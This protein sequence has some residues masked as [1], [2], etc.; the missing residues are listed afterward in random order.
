MTKPVGTAAAGGA[1]ARLLQRKCGCDASAEPNG[2]CTD[3][4]QKRLQRSAR[5]DG[6][7]WPRD[8]ADVPGVVHDVLRSPGRPLDAATRA[9]FEPRFGQEPAL[10][11]TA[12][13][14]A[15]SSSGGL[16]ISEP[17]D[18]GERE[19][20]RVAERVTRR[21]DGPPRPGGPGFDFSR[22]RVHADAQAAE[23]A[24]AVAARAYTVGHDIVFAAGQFAPTTSAGRGLLAHELAHV[25]QHS[26][27]LSRQP[28]PPPPRQLPPHVA[29]APSLRSAAAGGSTVPCA[30]TGCP[31]KI[32]G[33]AQ[34][35]VPGGASGE[36]FNA[37]DAKPSV[38]M[39]KFMTAEAPALLQGV[40][41]VLVSALS[42]LADRQITWSDCPNPP[43]D[44]PSAGCIWVSQEKEKEA[45]VF[46][47]GT[48]ATIGKQ[49]RE[50]WSIGTRKQL[51]WSA[52][53]IRF[54]RSPPPGLPAA[55][56]GAMWE[57][58]AL[59]G[60]LAAF[61]VSY[62]RAM[63]RPTPAEQQA[64]VTNAIDFL[65][66]NTKTLGVRGILTRLRC[67]LPCAE[68]DESIT[69]VFGELTSSW[70]REMRDALLFGLMDPARALG[71]PPR[72]G[73]P[74]SMTFPP[75]PHPKPK[76]LYVPR[77]GFERE[78]GKTGE[79]L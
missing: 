61:P 46:N 29:K 26:P 69:K 22:V 40:R 11:P 72:P 75:E 76:P 53:Q 44:D 25:A 43:A 64:A 73:M 19:A 57:L 23:S 51:S 30:T 47:Q 59:H 6:D 77:G 34:D 67:T 60:W 48:A 17:G 62:E 24:R 39:R 20:D 58:Q 28:A 8:P 54:R 55:N 41:D 12:T 56:A 4:R 52:D 32:P 63:S 37:P 33:S 49:S 79:N 68:V 13:A 7:P 3:C 42:A 78:A 21:S 36:P 27:G 66:D 5:G 74:P 38:Q 16:M 2:G 71:W 9:F 18:A 45:Q 31:A 1:P 70:P 50:D 10:R 14:R 65:V 15:A 35:W